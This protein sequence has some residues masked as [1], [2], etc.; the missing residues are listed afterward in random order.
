M[1]EKNKKSGHE[2]LLFGNIKFENAFDNTSA[3]FLTN[4]FKH[5]LFHFCFIHIGN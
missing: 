1:R 4:L 3:K 5:K 2:S